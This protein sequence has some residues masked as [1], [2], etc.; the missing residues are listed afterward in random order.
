MHTLRKMK[1]KSFNIFFLFLRIY[2]TFF[3]IFK[4]EN[5]ILK[6]TIFPLI[7]IFQLYMSW[8]TICPIQ[9]TSHTL[10]HSSWKTHLDGQD[11]SSLQLGGGV[12]QPL[13]NYPNSWTMDNL[14]TYKKL[15]TCI[16]YAT[17]NAFKSCTM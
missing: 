2:F 10:V 17:L 9:Y 14:S 5:I 7:H 15:M 8:F 1:R 12:L 4:Y 6:K 13:L 11:K 16:I 3:L